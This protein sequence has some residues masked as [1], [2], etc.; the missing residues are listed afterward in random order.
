MKLTYKSGFW[1]LAV[2]CLLLA[3]FSLYVFGY[4]GIYAIYAEDL[5][6]VIAEYETS[7]GE[8]CITCD[9][10]FGTE[11][12]VTGINGLYTSDEGYF[13]VWTKDR[14][15]EEIAETTMHELSHYY[16]AQYPDHFVDLDPQYVIK[17]YGKV[18]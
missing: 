18:V 4:L 9:M 3:F 15:A 17:K 16:I 2:C 8:R 11:N 1:M 13:C 14:S 6:K 7:E 10:R 12:N 5:E